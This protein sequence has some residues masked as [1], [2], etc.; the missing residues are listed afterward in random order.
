VSEP[1]RPTRVQIAGR[2]SAEWW[3]GVQRLGEAIEHAP[4]C[5]RPEPEWSRDEAGGATATCPECRGW[6]TLPAEPRIRPKVVPEPTP[7]NIRAERERRKA[8]GLA[9]GDDTLV[10]EVWPALSE[11]TIRRRRHEP[12]PPQK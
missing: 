12:G 6:A 9:Y 8:A 1:I 3:R 11:A 7:E 4:G 2:V 5:S 10:A